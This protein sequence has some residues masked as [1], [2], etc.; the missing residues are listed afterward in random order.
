MKFFSSPATDKIE[1][2]KYPFSFIAPTKYVGGWVRQITATKLP[3]ATKV[4][5]AQMRLDRGG[6][7]ELHWHV[8]AEWGYMLYGEARVTVVD[9]QGR[10]YVNDVKAGDTWDFPAGI[11]HS[12]Q[13]IGH[14]GAFFILGFNDGNFNPFDTFT[15]SDWISHTPKDIL[16][17]NFGVPSSTFDN[18]PSKLVYIFPGEMP[19]PLQFEQ[20]YAAQTTGYAPQSYTFSSSKMKPTVTRNGGTVKIIDRSNFPVSD[21]AAA[22]VTL[23]PGALRELH[24]HPNADEWQYYIQGRALVNYCIILPYRNLYFHLGSATM[25]MFNGTG[26]TITTNFQAGDVGYVPKSKGHYVENTGDVDL[27]FVELF[28]T[29]LYE[30]VSLASWLAHTPSRVV[31]ENTKTSEK[32]VASINKKKAVIQPF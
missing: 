18:I 5:G 28:P 21:F 29:P 27:V 10:G 23:K 19:R 1:T 20:N 31:S 14:D 7:R 25:G 12:I 15:V 4:A 26:I 22:I 3:V 17:K 16:A 8:E 9:E 30:D 6:V 13:G 32:F 2:Y 24:W 11:P